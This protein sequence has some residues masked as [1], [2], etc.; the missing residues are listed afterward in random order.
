M[1]FT[2]FKDWESYVQKLEAL[3]NQPFFIQNASSLTTS[4]ILKIIKS[5]RAISALHVHNDMFIMLEEDNNYNVISAQKMNTDNPIITFLTFQVSATINQD[6]FKM[7]TALPAYSLTK[8]HASSFSKLSSVFRSSVD[9][10]SSIRLLHL[11]ISLTASYD[12]S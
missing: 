12:T 4:H 2:L 10:F 9:K 7:V 8:F 1:G 3:I 5:L 6:F 11:K